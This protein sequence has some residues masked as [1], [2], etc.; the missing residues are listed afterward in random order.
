[1]SEIIKTEIEKIRKNLS[2]KNISDDR[3]F[4]FLL[5]NNFFGV[6]ITECEDF[7]SDGT[8]DGG[9]DFSWYDDEESKVIVCQAKYTGKLLNNDISAEFDKMNSTIDNFSN[10][11]TGSY[12]DRV[13]FILQNFLDCLPD[14]NT[15][16]IEYTLFTSADIDKQNVIKYLEKTTHNFSTDSITIYNFHDIEEKILENQQTL[17]MVCNDK[18][19]IDK[20]NNCLYYESNECEGVM[21]NISSK[22][23][24]D[25][26]NKYS[27]KGLFDLNIRRYIS[28]KLVDSG[29][30]KTLDED[31]DNFWFL[32]NGIIIACEEFN[33]D[34]NTVKLSKFSIVN[35]GQTTNRIGEYK[36]SNSQEFFIPCKIVAEKKKDPNLSFYT[37]IAEA[38]NSQK[39][40]LP[41]DLKSNTSEMLRL[42][43]WLADEKIFFEIKR[44]VKPD[45]Q[46]QHKIKNDEFGQLLL[47]FI[48]QRPGTSRSGKKAIFEN[49]DIYNRLFKQNYVNDADKKAFLIDLIH[50]NTIYSN[51]ESELKKN[52]EL[53]TMQ[54]EILKNG[55]QI[56]F[57]LLGVIYRLA[58]SDIDEKDFLK[59]LQIV[60]TTDFIYGAFISN[61]SKDDFY[62]K[63][64]QTIIDIVTIV[65]DSYEGMY[66][67]QLASSVSN[68]FKTDSKYIDCILKDF[69]N[70][71]RTIVGKDLKAQI[72]I[73]RR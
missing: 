42:S 2:N 29:I 43:N 63:F 73:F 70:T 32:N 59:D 10:G 40:I 60:K 15:G 48:L 72:D 3:L 66:Q 27:N 19:S 65:T 26:Y 68:Y 54:I 11:N 52:N 69:A 6:E 36:G 22:S 49:N 45:F 53:N 8:N 21:V 34:G 17:D 23:I 28:N 50:L 18:I 41:R 5:L 51:I 12:N 16:N 14:E 64:K 20:P 24:V 58:N 33:V 46:P 62:D 71:L 4:S 9:I 47:S 55:K 67:K 25:L 44:G 30:K 13:K 37:K 61:Y 1:M 57:A 38:T 39:P 56:I 35:G 31:R 7:I